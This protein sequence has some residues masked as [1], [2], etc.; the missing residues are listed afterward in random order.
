MLE[1]EICSL[2]EGSFFN[3]FVM[4]NATLHFEFISF[5]LVMFVFFGKTPFSV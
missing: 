4:I 5:T 1:R 3:S 2:A